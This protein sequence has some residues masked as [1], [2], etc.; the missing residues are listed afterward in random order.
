VVEGRTIP[1]SVTAASVLLGIKAA[2][3]I[4]LGLALL[5]VSSRRHFSLAGQVIAHR[6]GGLGLLLL[7]LAVLT[8]AVVVGLLRLSVYARVGAFVLE[9]VSIVLSLTRIAHRPGLAILSIGISVVVIVLLL[10]GTSSRAFQP[11]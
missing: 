9:G 11:T 7:V 10:T 6:R 5:A 2:L 8:I 4:L 1:G 3:G